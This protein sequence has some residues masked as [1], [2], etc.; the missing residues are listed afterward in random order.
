MDNRPIAV[1]D[2]GVGGLASLGAIRDAMPNENIIFFGDTAFMPFG[3]KTEEELR[4]RAGL[5]AKKMASFDAKMIII[6]CNTMSCVAINEMYKA[7]PM[8]LIQSM[9]EPCCKSVLKCEDSAKVGLIATPRCIG[10]G[11]YKKTFEGLKNHP[12]VYPV[13]IP[14]LSV[15]IE[16]GTLD[17]PKMNELL[18]SYLDGV[19]KNDGIEY[20]LLGCT[21]Y[22]L[23]SNAILS[24]YP[25][26][27]LL[28]PCENLA[29]SAKILLKV[30]GLNAEEEREGKL[31]IY[32]SKITQGFSSMAEKL[33]LSGI[34]IKEISL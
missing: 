26:L 19:V 8:L 22:P 10:T 27:K 2:S 29:K 16:E 13:G 28:D 24:L 1:I 34:E 5:I 32:A 7:A 23:A 20:L 18:S 4:E 15:Y 21:H 25:N 3:T 30:H 11:L 6:A 31:E 12:T 14:E 9:V 33:G 17:G